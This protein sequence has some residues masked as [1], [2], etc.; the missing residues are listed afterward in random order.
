MSQKNGGK[1]LRETKKEKGKTMQ[2]VKVIKVKP[3][4]DK[5]RE[6]IKNEL[7]RK[8]SADAQWEWV[9][10]RWL[11]AMV[12]GWTGGSS[13]RCVFQ[14][15]LAPL[16]V[17]ERQG[18]GKSTFCRS[19]LPPVL[20]RFYLDKFDI[21]AESHAEKRLGTMALINMEELDEQLADNVAAGDLAAARTIRARY[22]ELSR[23]IAK[24]RMNRTAGNARLPEVTAEDVAGVISLWS[25][26]P[27]Q[28]LTERE[29]ERLLKLEAQESRSEV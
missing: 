6:E 14:N 28:R 8:V 17:S 7:A 25:K 16:L 20:R 3:G 22:E 13:E 10:R 27:V 12:S 18:L 29:S 21:N 23:R 4:R 24:R 5:L 2:Q 9:F 15:Q 11:R 1:G 26:V 19:L